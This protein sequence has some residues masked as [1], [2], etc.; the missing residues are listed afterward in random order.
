[1]K[2]VIAHN[3]YRIA[4]G[5]E[6]HVDL[7][8]GALATRGVEV[9][10]FERDAAAVE[11]SMIPR[12]R[13]ALGL[14]Y[15]PSSYR[16]FAEWLDARSVD[17]VHFHNIWPRLTPA[18][19]RAA[20]SRARVLMTVH[21]YR[22]A[23]PAGTL[24]WGD[25]IHD[26]CITGSSLACAIHNPR[27][28]WPESIAYGVALEIQ[29]RMYMLDRW[30]D[31]LVTPSAFAASVVERSGIGRGRIEV[32][33]YGIPMSEPP[34]RESR[35]FALYVGR[36]SSEKGLKT[37]LEA[38]TRSNIPLVVAGEGPLAAICVGVDGVEFIGRQTQSA[39][40]DLRSRAAFAVVP[41]EWFDVLPFAAIEALAAGLPVI[42]TRIGGL[43]E[44][45]D[46]GE[47]GV[48][49]EPRNPQALAD[50][51]RDMLQDMERLEAM[52]ER[53]RETAKHRF[54]IDRQ[55]ARLLELYEGAGE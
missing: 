42:A 45:V 9:E 53:G 26:T 10:R 39:L 22:F 47:T 43:P 7:L 28:S 54:S 31:L 16:D 3:R 51:M 41:S 35:E 5:E 38:A 25:R 19:L 20:K 2:V 13:L 36:L 21:N 12:L 48:L 18:A 30:T 8:G 29:R 23:C 11:R 24:L 52:G 1:M 49:V 15:R 17:V 44:I 55:A 50:A 4:G 14:A 27:R 34:P 37:L 33:P 6:R 46:D 32:V 40:A